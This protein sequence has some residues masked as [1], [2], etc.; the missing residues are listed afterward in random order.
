MQF[1]VHGKRGILYNVC[2]VPRMVQLH[3]EDRSSISGF[4]PTPASRLPLPLPAPYCLWGPK[5][6]GQ[7]LRSVILEHQVTR[8]NTSYDIEC[9]P[10]KAAS[11]TRGAWGNAAALDARGEVKR[12]TGKDAGNCLPFIISHS[13]SP[14]SKTIGDGNDTSRRARVSL[15]TRSSHHHHRLSHRIPPPGTALTNKAQPRPGTAGGFW[16]I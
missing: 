15:A 13:S 5:Q 16:I 4:M 11:R 14:G 8:W 6:D 3:R 7:A 12:G 2:R 1:D 9:R 10:M